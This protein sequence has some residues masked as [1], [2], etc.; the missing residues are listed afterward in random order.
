MPLSG[1]CSGNS[2]SRARTGAP[3]LQPEGTGEAEQVI[4]Q[5]RGAGTS[6][7]CWTQHPR[8]AIQGWSLAPPARN[9]FMPL[10]SL[11]QQPLQR[12]STRAQR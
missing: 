8:S 12:I 6:P 5:C 11:K 3:A 9:P 1:G 2:K 7:A 10:V 4:G